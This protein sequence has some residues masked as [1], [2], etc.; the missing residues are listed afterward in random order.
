MAELTPAELWRGNR[1]GRGFPLRLAYLDRLL[2]QTERAIAGLKRSKRPE[3]A[4]RL[5]ELEQVHQG[6]LDMKEESLMATVREIYQYLDGLAPF[7][8]QMEFDNA[9]F[10]VGRGEQT[11]SKILVSLDI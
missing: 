10:L 6:L 11:V 4:S 3:D 1:P 2:R 8:L 9:G 5:A 7:S